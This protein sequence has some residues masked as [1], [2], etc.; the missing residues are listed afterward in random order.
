MDLALILVLA[1]ILALLLL[2]A[3]FS[4][5]ETALTA[6]SRSRMH[7]MSEQGD[8]RARLVERL[9]ERRERLISAIL[10]GNNAVNILA[11]ALAT[12]ALIGLFGEAGVAYATI[13][14]TLLVFVFAEVLPKTYAIRN[15][16]RLA[17]FLAPILN[18]V[19]AVLSPVTGA[20]QWLVGGLLRALGKESTGA[21]AMSAAD[22]LRG[23]F[24]LHA[25]E[26]R[27]RKHYRDMLR[28][29]LDLSEVEVGEI[30]IHRKNMVTVDADLPVSRV[31]AEVLDSPFTRVPLWR[32]DP[33]NI[34]G[35]LHAKGMLRAIRT[36]DGDIDQLNVMELAYEPWFVPDTT[37][38]A[39][40]LAAFRRRREHFALV[41][42]EYG[43]LEGLVT[44]EDI[45]EEIVGD[46]A[47]EHDLPTIGVRRQP[48]GSF[49]VAGEVTI[50][51][52]N[53]ALD[54][55][56]PDEEAATV[57][58]LVL[59]E[60]E[61]IPEA[62]Q[63]FVF[64]DFEFEVLEREQNRITSLRLRPRAEAVEDE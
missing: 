57:A 10:L 4:G 41:V 35:V 60:A 38:L 44:L 31:V 55:R 18:V 15:A 1:G 26:G 47:D 6:T 29:I 53:R 22:E 11:S 21:G 51:D 54:C 14:M 27:V 48:D 36:H 42:D 37:S 45:I 8:K 30:M 2:S 34:V 9:I 19:V 20:I 43:T 32:E 25:H 59:H 23:I 61:R 63:S 24:D 7:H 28:S 13:V 5:S 62:G 40:Q 16:D 56:L 39:E 12:S 52:L 33:D 58:G 49:V 46:I 3:F 17:V 64:H 50:R